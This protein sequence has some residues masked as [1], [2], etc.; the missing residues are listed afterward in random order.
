[1]GMDAHRYCVAEGGHETVI[2]QLLENGA[3]PDSKDDKG[4][5]TLS[6]EGQRY[7]FRAG[8]RLTREAAKTKPALTKD[9]S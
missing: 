5:T 9:K 8:L 2:K 6:C 7:D 3:Q 4:Q 1:M